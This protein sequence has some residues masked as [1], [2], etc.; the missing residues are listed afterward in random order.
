MRPV[1]VADHSRSPCP[2]SDRWWNL[3]CPSQLDMALST[4][5]P[6]TSCITSIASRCSSGARKNP[7]QMLAAACGRFRVVIPQEASDHAPRVSDQFITYTGGTDLAIMLNK[8][9]FEPDTAVFVITEASSSKDTWGMAA[10]VVRG[11]LR[12]PSLSG[13]PTV[14][15][16][17]VHVRNVVAKKRDNSTALLRRLY[18][19]MLQHNVDFIGGDFSMSALSKIGDVF[20]D[21]EFCGTWQLAPMG[22]RCLGRYVS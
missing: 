16:C 6:V 4:T 17:S 5:R 13:I 10:L 14:T 8:D 12:R 9:T 11:L 20:T 1:P 7:T 19:H 21:S 15:F 18:A 2:L 3:R 22:S